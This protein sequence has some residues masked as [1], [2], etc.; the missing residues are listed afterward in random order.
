MN[1]PKE[2]TVYYA[3]IVDGKPLAIT[4]IYIYPEEIYIGDFEVSK[5]SRGMGLGKKLFNAILNEYPNMDFSL[6][7]RDE[8]A[9]QFWQKMGFI[10]NG[11]GRYMVRQIK[12]DD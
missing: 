10:P 6:C 12:G 9:K 2:D 3:W 7:Y 5:Y 1:D 8:K 4:N 11:N